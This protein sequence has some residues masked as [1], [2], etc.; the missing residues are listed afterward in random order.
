[1]SKFSIAN[2]SS[3]HTRFIRGRH[4]R[5]WKPPRLLL[6]G[7]LSL[8]LTATGI[9]A[10]FAESHSGSMV[11]TTDN[12]VV[13]GARVHGYLHVK[14]DN[15]T[16]RN[17]TI[18]YGGA[19]A[20]RV[21]EGHSGTVVED[22]RIHCLSDRTNGLVFGNYTATRVSATGCRHGFLFSAAAPATILDSVVDGVPVDVSEGSGRDAT[23]GSDL[24]EVAG[25]GDQAEAAMAAPV[26][27]GVTRPLRQGSGV[28]SDSDD[29]RESAA[30]TDASGVPTSFPG[31]HNTGVP[32]GTKLTAA[33]SQTVTTDGQVLSG[34]N[35]KGCVTVR[36]KNVVIRN[37]RI[38]CSGPYSIRTINAVNLLVEDVEIDGQGK[39]SAAVCCDAYTLRRVEI[40]NVIDG[41][42]LGNNVVV[43]YSWIHHLKRSGKSHN[44]ALQT[45][46]SSNILIRGNTLEAYN[47]DTND[48]M[49][50]CLQMGST[51]GPIVSNLT[52]EYNY[53][54]GG[55]Y[56][57]SFDKRLNA[58]SIRLRNNVFGRQHRFGVI[59][60]PTQSGIIWDRATNLYV[61]TRQPVV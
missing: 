24:V 36:A 12:A 37:S 56:S 49:N 22:T 47:P 9:R 27:R 45:T 14:A 31:P 32:K 21:F 17:S 13:D 20:L 52:F 55:N 48:P 53:C 26:S 40:R 30:E 39:N 42:R 3:R 50:G 25:P 8:G 19:H 34:L 16:I 6:V 1:M 23:G 2:G 51:T 7:V 33:G 58:K 46:G 61:D 57:I 28:D 44:D 11:I 15:V 29:S 54:N 5:S 38:T 35:I 18:R 41:P 4:A 59:A 60:R 10:A 43:E